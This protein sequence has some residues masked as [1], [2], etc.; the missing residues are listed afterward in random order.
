MEQLKTEK[1]VTKLERER[2]VELKKA[3]LD[4]TKR[5]NDIVMEQKQNEVETA[6]DIHQNIKEIPRV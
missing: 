6:Q 3:K 4:A 2:N 1:K 5:G